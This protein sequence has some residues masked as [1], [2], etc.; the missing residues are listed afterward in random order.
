M[1]SLFEVLLG[2]K[3]IYDVISGKSALKKNYDLKLKGVVYDEEI[4]S[5]SS[6]GNQTS[7]VDSKFV[8]LNRIRE[9]RAIM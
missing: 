6:S 1:T 4:L 5:V 7:Y 3:L 8:L 2:N 9:Y